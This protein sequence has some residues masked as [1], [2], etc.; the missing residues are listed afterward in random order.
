MANV[1]EKVRTEM[2]NISAV[3]EELRQVK[4]R[5]DKECVVLVGMGGFLQSIYTGMENILKQVLLAKGI[6]LPT[7]STWHKDL[8][9]LA[10]AHGLVT[11]ATSERMGRYLVFRHF[12]A[13][14][15]GF[16]VHE[17]RLKPLVDGV[18]DVYS[19]F[20]TEVER[21]LSKD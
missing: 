8:L 12:F 14:S 4:D 10:V 20:R 19:K 13:H 6:R 17:A 11:E 1:N 18:S 16:L 2:E 5:P 15:Y 9:S 3:L 21:F 7:T